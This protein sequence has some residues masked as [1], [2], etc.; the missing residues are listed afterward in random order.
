MSIY[1]IVRPC[2]YCYV[3]VQVF[4][5]I[6]FIEQYSPFFSLG[7]GLVALLSRKKRE[8]PLDSG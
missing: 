5:R 3:A 4:Y 2:V 1:Y 7:T 8:T 6:A